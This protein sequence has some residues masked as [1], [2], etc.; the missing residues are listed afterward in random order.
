MSDFLNLEITEVKGLQA[1]RLPLRTQIRGLLGLDAR[2]LPIPIAERAAGIDT[3]H[4]N[5]D[6]NFGFNPLLRF[7]CIKATQG[8]SIFDDQYLNSRNKLTNMELPFHAFHYLTTSDGAAQAKWFIDHIQDNPGPIPPVIDVELASVAGNLV[9]ACVQRVYDRMR[10]WPMIYTSAYYWS[11]VSGASDKLWIAQR[12]KLFVAH[13]DTD[14]PILPLD[15]NDYFI[16][17][18]SANGNKQG[19][20][21]GAP[22]PPE[23]DPDMDLDRCRKSWLAQYEPVH[24]NWQWDVTNGLRALG[25]TV[26]DPE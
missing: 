17:Q 23:A 14:S 25:Q 10:L 22:P 5:G 1:G 15:W 6:M 20:A 18:H 19:V 3:S 24:D 26:R 4:W 8:V 13:W 21:W 9:R 7:V 11:L 16:H 2:G 12:C